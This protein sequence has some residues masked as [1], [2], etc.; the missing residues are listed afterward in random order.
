MIFSEA[1]AA[2]SICSPTRASILT[3][4]HPARLRLTDYIPGRGNRPEFAMQVPDTPKQLPRSE[5][6][7]AEALDQAGY[8]TAHIGKWHL[9]GKRHLPTD[10]GFD[11][12][13]AGASFGMPQK[14][15][16]FFSPYNNPHLKDGRPGEYLTDRLTLEA[17]KQMKQFSEKPK[18]PWFLMMNYYAVH[19]PIQSRA[20]REAKYKD[21]VPVLHWKNAAYAGMVE[22]VDDSVGRLLKQLRAQGQERDT[23]VVLFSDNGGLHWFT[24]NHPLRAG[25]GWLYE[26]G[27]RV[28]MIV[29][30]PG[31]VAAGSLVEAPV[32]STDFYP[33][34]LE[35][36]GLK[37][38]PQ[39]H[40]DG[41][42]LM[43]LLR[44]QTT[45]SPHDALYW[46]YPHYHG[47]GERPASAIRAGRYK[48]IRRY[49][50]G[51]RELYNMEN[52]VG[53]STNLAD[54]HP[55]VAS[56]LDRRLQRWLASVKAVVPRRKSSALPAVQ[57]VPPPTQQA[58]P[59]NL[60]LS[61][62]PIASVEK[63]FLSLQNC[64]ITETPTGFIL[65]SP[66][67]GTAVSATDLSADANRTI[68][69][70]VPFDIRTRQEHLFRNALVVAGPDPQPESMLQFAYWEKQKRITIGGFGDGN[71]R[72]QTD[73]LRPPPNGRGVMK[74][75]LT[76]KEARLE[77]GGSTARLPLSAPLTI[78]YVGYG[79]NMGQTHF[80]MMKATVR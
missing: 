52:D 74:L 80:E 66:T 58:L 13:I 61:G 48:L 44:G 69:L 57:E 5:F 62:A 22:G 40:A 9:G 71:G 46:H 37:T 18:R 49:E 75:T 45:T 30:W 77:L 64:R 78:R 10:Q 14:P 47:A 34:I 35:A 59:E 76:P 16:Y 67:F 6:T 12:N 11:V 4:K 32:C 17:V 3:G 56:Q 29:R 24:S 33:T 41:R 51:Q 54:T 73:V 15:N 55:M 50:T 8:Q 43:P 38:N 25:K 36:A 26:G 31:K 20:D 72:V 39:Q 65:D 28:P 7:L 42:S 19:S 27:I 53:E 79:V 23:I 2:A 21:Q 70:E 63:H 1:Y 60:T 68:E